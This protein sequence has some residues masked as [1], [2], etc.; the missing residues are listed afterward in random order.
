MSDVDKELKAYRK[1]HLLELMRDASEYAYCAGW[2]D[3]LEFDLWRFV[4]GTFP[5][6]KHYD[7]I[8]HTNYTIEIAEMKRLAALVD[9]WWIWDEG[10]TF[11]TM[12]EWL[13]MFEKSANK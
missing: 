10:E 8:T 5:K 9:G 2:M 13:P 1:N 11:I 6:D 7:L 4:I 12:A 3:G